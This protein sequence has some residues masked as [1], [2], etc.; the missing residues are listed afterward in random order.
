MSVLEE[1]A[2]EI[3]RGLSNMIE[4]E[5]PSTFI[6][7]L[8]MERLK[9]IDE[10]AYVRFASVYR[11]FKDVNTLMAEIEKLRNGRD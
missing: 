7:E 11:Q 10:I 4:K 3:E 8:V 9:G 2:N 1:L 6:G 5:I